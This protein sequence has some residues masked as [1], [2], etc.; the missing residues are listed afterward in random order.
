MQM[1][2][3][4][5]LKLTLP[6]NFYGSS[7]LMIFKF[8]LTMK[9]LSITRDVPEETFA[10]RGKSSAYQQEQWNLFIEFYV[11]EMHWCENRVIV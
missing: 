2:I 11:V 8:F 5:I 1:P 7:H 10:K 3:P 9:H 6:V 4:G